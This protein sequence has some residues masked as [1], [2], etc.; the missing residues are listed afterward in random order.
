MTAACIVCSLTAA[1]VSGAAVR[2]SAS[3]APETVVFP[4]TK[5]IEYRL[6]LENDGPRRSFA[7]SMAPAFYAYE[8]GAGLE[9]SPLGRTVAL[10]AE[11]ALELGVFGSSQVAHPACSPTANRYHGYEPESFTADVSLGTGPGTLVV[12]RRYGDHAPWP[13]ADLRLAF[14]LTNDLNGP[15]AG[16]LE[17]E[18]TVYP[19]AP[20]RGGPTGV[21]IG[22]ATRPATGR[23]GLG[24]PTRIAGGV[25]IAVA[26]R[27]DPPL[28][29][30][31]IALRYYAPEGPR[32]LATLG[33]V[34]VDERGRFELS[35][36]RP[37]AAGPYELWAFYDSTRAALTDDH[38]CP[39]GFELADPYTPPPGPGELRIRSRSA[40][41][42]ARGA[43][44]LRVTCVGGGRCTTRLALRSG[45]E[46]LATRRIEMT[47]GV[48]QRYEL[49][50]PRRWRAAARRAGRLVLTVTARG[51]RRTLVLRA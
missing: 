17:Q 13:D 35:G 11:G 23:P 34:D 14:R 50:L 30:G 16:D 46:P 29:G 47:A 48:A 27:T 2:A 8:N 12:R 41:L 28:P 24:T 6:E 42:T 39:R 49:L 25:P 10:R 43:V 38:A 45:S 22:L 44:P 33:V 40:R 4:A 18:L 5:E 15:G 26:G 7:V 51:V 36:W 20:A 3:A 1:P 31:R 21:R 32:E 19:P 37:R 9:G